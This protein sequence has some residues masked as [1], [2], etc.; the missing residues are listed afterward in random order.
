MFTGII[1]RVGKI[2]VVRATYGNFSLGIECDAI[3]QTSQ[4]GDSISVDGV[5]L[6]INAIQDNIF[7]VDV[8]HE[9]LLRSHLG[10]VK[11]GRL[12]N[13]EKA[14][15]PESLMGGH[16]VQGHVDSVGI[17]KA[18]QRNANAWDLAVTADPDVIK[19]LIP[20]A[21]IAVN[22]VSLTVVTVS[23]TDFGVSII[24]TTFQ[25]TN[26]GSLQCAD[27]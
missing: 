7:M 13:L 5:C 17:V 12:V 23:E 9:T 19:L 20:K 27:E 22:G 8:M 1:Q 21:S 18:I 15:L 24:P 11:V 2:N 26:L 14:L 3:A 10:K 25:D 6:T 4:R 16:L